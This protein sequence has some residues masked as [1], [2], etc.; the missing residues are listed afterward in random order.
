MQIALRQFW[1]SNW[2]IAAAFSAAFAVCALGPLNARLA[3]LEAGFLDIAMGWAG[4]VPGH[5]IAVIA[6]DRQSI[7]NIGPWPWDRNVLAEVVDK[8]GAAGA[9]RIALTLRMDTP[10]NQ[11]GL[12]HLQ[13]AKKMVG[14]GDAAVYLQQ[15]IAELDTDSR[16][17]ASMRAAGNVFLPLDFPRDGMGGGNATYDGAAVAWQSSSEPADAPRASH[18]QGPIEV[19]GTEA[20]GLGHTYMPKDA[21]GVSRRLNQLVLSQG[22]LYPA[23][24]LRLLLPI[25]DDSPLR[26]SLSANN[27]L[28]LDTLSMPV[29]DTLSVLVHWYAPRAGSA[30]FALDSFWDVFAGNT[31]P[32]KFRDKIVLIGGTDPR[33]ARTVATP[34]GP[35]TPEVTALAHSVSTIANQH[36]TLRPDWLAYAEPAVYCLVALY[37]AFLVTLPAWRVA[38]LISG[39]IALIL[40]ASSLALLLTQG[41]WI[42]LQGAIFFLILGHALMA[43]KRLQLL[44]R[45]RA[46]TPTDEQESDRMLGL[47][48]QEQG[49]L[50]LALDKFRKLPLDDSMMEILYRLALD[51]ERKRK[52]DRAGQIYSHMAEYDADYR[53]I[54]QRMQLSQRL[55]DTMTLGTPGVSGR[56][57]VK[58]ERDGSRKPTLGRYVVD[59]ELGKGAMGVVYLATDPSLNRV[60]ALKAI[61]LAEEFDEEDLGGI[62]ERF[63]REAETAGKLN[64]PGIVAVY[65][66]G[67]DNDVAFIAMEYVEGERLGDYS[68][69]TQLLPARTVMELVARTADAL[70]YAHRHGVVHRDIKPSNLLY[71]KQ[72]DRLKIT[73]FGVA[74]LTDSKRTRTGLVLGTPSYMSPEQI[75]G[76]TVTGRSDLFSLGVTLYQ[77]LTG[78]LPFRA[79]SLAKLMFKI[80]NE[81]H[82][83]IRLIRE[84]LPECV[85][86]ILGKALAKQ[87][88]DRF[89]NGAEMALALRDCMGKMPP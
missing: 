82:Q 59:K 77:L 9:R 71:N 44:Q 32:D 54:Q 47:A 41:I 81:P 87:P 35:E 78:F 23:L 28:S 43:F 58:L 31:P 12:Y 33:I 15:A 10:Q 48:F 20:A 6:I 34:L 52:F 21:D 75:E 51:C 42:K 36:F 13:Q 67:E 70:N 79:D 24:A 62:K 55:E 18:V 60:V 76:E 63:F 5:D 7:E 61:P 40:L 57:P 22:R 69:P 89:A 11:L 37:L 3:G 74:R 53:D 66:A 56:A 49:Q 27:I 50:D 8:L 85:E 73:D 68:G 39:G 84:E 83:P 30:P 2:F 16:L 26:A 1:R 86:I 64:H 88:A 4:D 72:Q 25:V 14:T 46:G 38:A 17:A 80:A 45:L 29:D 65:D 19:L